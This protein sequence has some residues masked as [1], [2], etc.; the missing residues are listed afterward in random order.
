MAG[1]RLPGKLR[2][3]VG[4]PVVGVLSLGDTGLVVR[5]HSERELRAVRLCSPHAVIVDGG[6]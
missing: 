6:A 4:G 5:Y 2:R 3:V 1:C